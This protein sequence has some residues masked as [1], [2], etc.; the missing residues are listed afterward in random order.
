MRA[1]QLRD[2][3]SA[4]GC[5]TDPADI[6]IDMASLRASYWLARTIR[7]RY[8]VLDLVY[9]TGVLDACP[10]GAVRAGR[11]LGRRAD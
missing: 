10:C 5:P 11:L 2:L 6:G 4:A 7:N 1:D 8:T 9:E 3:L